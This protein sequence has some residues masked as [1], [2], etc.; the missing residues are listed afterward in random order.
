ML[1]TFNNLNDKDKQK[2][3]G[4][5]KTHGVKGKN[6]RDEGIPYPFFCKYLGLPS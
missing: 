3:Q 5:G 2:E 4:K 1:E 6:E